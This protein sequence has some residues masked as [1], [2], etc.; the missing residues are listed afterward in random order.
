VQ[1]GKKSDLNSLLAE[2]GS[3]NVKQQSGVFSANKMMKASEFIALSAPD[4]SI[5]NQMIAGKKRVFTTSRLRYTTENM[6]DSSSLE[7]NLKQGGALKAPIYNVGA[8]AINVLPSATKALEIHEHIYAG[9]PE[10][11]ENDK[12][13]GIDLKINS[14]TQ[15]VIIGEEKQ[16]KL[17]QIQAFEGGVLSMPSRL[18]SPSQPLALMKTWLLNQKTRLRLGENLKPSRPLILE[19]RVIVLSRQ[20]EH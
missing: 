13:Q 14:F 6:C 3:I 7:I 19:Q 1:V 10:S 4:L 11:K 2:Q 20:E 15:P 8:V 16:S 17:V 5:Q 18:I 12:R 9:C